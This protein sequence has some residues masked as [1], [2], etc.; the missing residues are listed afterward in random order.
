MR[1]LVVDD[2]WEPS[3]AR[4]TVE[5]VRPDDEDFATKLESADGFDILLVDQNLELDVTLSMRAF[6]GAS[7]VGH[8]RSWSRTRGT[9]L[10]PLVITTS[11][12]EA[13]KSEVPTVGP[14]IPVGGTFVGREHRLA[15]SLDVEWLLDKTDARLPEK[16]ESLSRAWSSL[17][18]AHGSINALPILLGLPF[19]DDKDSPHWSRL[20][21]AA[22]LEVTLQFGLA[23]VDNRIATQSMLRWLL[24]RTLAFPGILVSDAYAAWALGVTRD[25]LEQFSSASKCEVLAECVYSGLLSELFPRRWWLAGID[26]LN[27]E[28]DRRME[29]N[30]TQPGARQQFLSDF[31]PGSALVDHQTAGTVIAWTVD[32]MEGDLIDTEQ[33]VQLRPPGWPADA[34]FPWASKT[35]VARDE[36][37]RSMVPG[38]EAPLV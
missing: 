31:L 18:G 16:V 19:R 26:S 38:M 36:L 5:V 7:L 30:A 23:G 6:D 1:A 35:E 14:S 25:S 13:F 34:I 12:A 11:D 2:E 21:H 10:P 3:F 22:V 4:L 37:L 15:P 27:W 33:A 9:G 32:L 20:A 24:H 17:L 28:I 29:E 8:F